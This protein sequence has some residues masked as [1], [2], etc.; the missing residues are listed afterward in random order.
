ML[1]GSMPCSSPA[2][3]DLEATRPQLKDTQE[4]LQI[5]TLGV[6]CTLYLWY[7]K[8]KLILVPQLPFSP[9]CTP[10]NLWTNTASCLDK[11]GHIQFVL[12][13]T[14]GEKWSA[15][16]RFR[17]LRAILDRIAIFHE[18]SRHDE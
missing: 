15:R 8:T 10:A 6:G 4:T 12:C 11:L 14:P 5:A 16:L 7:I 1:E 3:T 2:D 17:F 18:R 13:W 9:V